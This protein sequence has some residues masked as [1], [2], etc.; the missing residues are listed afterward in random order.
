MRRSRI[1]QAPRTQPSL[2]ALT[3][4]CGVTGQASFGRPTPRLQSSPTR[5][6]RANMVTQTASNSICRI[7]TSV[8]LREAVAPARSWSFL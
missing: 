4:E 8:K 7:R 3:E 1:A 6:R 2:F 5:R